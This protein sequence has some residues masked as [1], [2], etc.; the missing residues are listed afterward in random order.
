VA[1]VTIGQP[2][3][4]IADL[5][6][7]GHLPE[8]YGKVVLVDF[9]ATWCTPCRASFPAYDALQRELGERGLV[10]IGVSVDQDENHYNRFVDKLSP[11]FATVRDAGQRFVTAVHP[12]AM[13]TCYLI[14]RHGVLQAVHSGFHGGATIRQLRAEIIKLLE[15]TL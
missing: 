11:S 13:P 7:I 8:Q 2:F 4:K 15:E 6:V 12:T 9:W 1:D 14:D 10:I 5:G 3:P